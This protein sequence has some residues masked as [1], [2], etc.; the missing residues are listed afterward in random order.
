MI[1]ATSTTDEL[2]S[3]SD[4]DSTQQGGGSSYGRHATDIGPREETHLFDKQTPPPYLPLSAKEITEPVYDRLYRG[5]MYLSK[6]ILVIIL[7]IFTV[8]VSALVL[9]T[10]IATGTLKP[11]CAFTEEDKVRFSSSRKNDTL[12]PSLLRSIQDL[13]ANLWEMRGKVEA[14]N[15]RVKFLEKQ[16]YLHGGLINETE[17]KAAFVSGFDMEQL[18]KSVNALKNSESE[19]KSMLSE[20]Q[21]NHSLVGLTSSGLADNVTKLQSRV[22]E[23]R[24]SNSNLSSRAGS[25]ERAVVHM[26]TELQMLQ[27]VY[28]AQN[29]SHNALQFEYKR[30]EAS[31]A[32]VNA[33]LN[34]KLSRGEAADFKSCVH[35]RISGTAVA[36]GGAALTTAEYREPSDKRAIGITCSTDYARHYILKLP[37]KGLYI[38]ECRGVSPAASHLN[39]SLMQCFLHVWECPIKT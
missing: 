22:E 23:L 15:S 26:S 16:V 21:Q 2:P 11:K 38:C 29:A 25:M 30:L 28:D 3:N 12:V 32:A 18:N 31:I 10:L 9:G 27:T 20:L 36:V 5:G 37:S 17:R 33:T 6:S 35:R 34:N 1:C 7:V 19:L 8:S 14:T 4:F 13:H 39:P 24:K